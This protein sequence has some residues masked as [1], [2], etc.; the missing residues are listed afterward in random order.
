MAA[1]TPVGGEMS[2][3]SYLMHCRP[4]SAAA[5]LQT[6]RPAKLLQNSE[7]EMEK[8]CMPSGIRTALCT[9]KKGTVRQCEARQDT[10]SPFVV[11]SSEPEAIQ[12]RLH[13]KQSQLTAIRNFGRTYAFCRCMW[14]QAC[15]PAPAQDAVC[16]SFSVIP[17]SG[18]CCMLWHR[19]L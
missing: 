16:G 11:Q 3:I 1:R 7:T 2:R 17:T 9:Q 8:N 10:T 18:Y 12:Q 15:I 13:K 4:Q 6:N 14:Q 19:V 5:S